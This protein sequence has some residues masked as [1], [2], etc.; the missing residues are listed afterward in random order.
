MARIETKAG[1]GAGKSLELRI[2]EACDKYTFA[3]QSLDLKWHD[4]WFKC[5]LYC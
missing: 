4:D 2:D 1:H 3:A 5:K